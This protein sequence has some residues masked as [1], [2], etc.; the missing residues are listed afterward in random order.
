MSASTIAEG[1]HICKFKT[2]VHR[3]SDRTIEVLQEF[4]NFFQGACLRPGGG[5]AQ[6][7]FDFT[8]GQCDFLRQVCSAL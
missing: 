6:W 5:N 2:P 4:L 8:L 1:R 3:S 7:D